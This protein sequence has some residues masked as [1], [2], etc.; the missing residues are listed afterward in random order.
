[1][2]IRSSYELTRLFLALSDVTRQQLL[3]QLSEPTSV[4]DICT[5]FDILVHEAVR[6][7]RRLEDV[8]LIRHLPNGEYV[9]SHYGRAIVPLVEGLS[10]VHDLLE[11]WEGHTVIELPA[12]LLC[13]PA[14][15][16]DLS[17]GDTMLHEAT[18]EA[19]DEATEFL[20]VLNYP[21][22]RS[23]LNVL[24]LKI[25]TTGGSGA[26]GHARVIDDVYSSLVINEYRAF[27]FFPGV[28]NNGEYYN[29]LTIGFMIRES[30]PTY[31]LIAEF[32][33]FLW[34][35]GHVPSDHI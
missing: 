20:W 32:F 33:S 14:Q 22:D 7:L 15:L 23:R 21:I 31:R 30:N 29:D 5:T 8:A 2:S 26:N 10:N 9:I 17:L 34:D 16:N 25:L 3:N 24:E 11:Y 4:I 27:T 18:Q 1:M 12:H 35:K 6:H 13:L 19:I 28:K